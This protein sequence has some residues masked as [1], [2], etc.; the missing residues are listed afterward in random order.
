MIALQSDT[1]IQ[2]VGRTARVRSVK[3]E[4]GA[5]PRRYTCRCMYLLRPSAKAGHWETEK[6]ERKRKK[7]TSQ[8]TCFDAFLSVPCRRQISALTLRI[9][10]A[11]F[12]R[13]PFKSLKFFRR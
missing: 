7:G 13:P 2:S 5:N 6:A 10:K 4:R 11:A 3:R 8:K 9:E 12:W 1:V